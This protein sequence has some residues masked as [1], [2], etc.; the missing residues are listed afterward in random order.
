[1][2]KLEQPFAMIAPLAAPR[3]PAN[4]F[5]PGHASLQ[6]TGRSA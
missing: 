2:P 1:M 4:A 3:S 5:A 6:P